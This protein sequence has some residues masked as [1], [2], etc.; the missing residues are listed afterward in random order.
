[1]SLKATNIKAWVEALRNPRI[2]FR[3]DDAPCRGATRMFVA[4]SDGNPVG[5]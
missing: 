1:M 4:Y 2:R 5:H 3:L